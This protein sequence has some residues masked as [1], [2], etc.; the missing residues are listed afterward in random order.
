VRLNVSSKQTKLQKCKLPY[1]C[2]HLGWT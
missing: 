2:L 1:M